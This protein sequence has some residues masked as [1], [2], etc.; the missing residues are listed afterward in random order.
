M[1]NK[2]LQW[3]KLKVIEADLVVAVL[4]MMIWIVLPKVSDLRGATQIKTKS[5]TR[6]L[7]ITN[8]HCNFRLQQIKIKN[9]PYSNERVFQNIYKN[10][11]WWVT[12]S[13]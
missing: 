1:N 2:R 12:I 8:R 13:N 3:Y 10:N 7:S 4:V 9:H 6:K 11:Q 5:Q